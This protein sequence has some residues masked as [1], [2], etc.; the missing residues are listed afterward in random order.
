MRNSTETKVVFRVKSPE[1]AQ[2]L[3]Y[4]VLPLNLE[5]PV[6]ASI[7][8]TQ[9]GYA[10]GKLQNET[11]AVHEGDGESEAVHAAEGTSRG[12]TELETWASALSR[13]TGTSTASGSASSFG[14][15]FSEGAANTLASMESMT[16]S[17][18]PNTQTFLAVNL[19]LGMNIGSADSSS[20]SLISSKTFQSAESLSR[21]RGAFGN[22]RAHQLRRRRTCYNRCYHRFARQIARQEQDPRQH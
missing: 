13:A 19:P 20:Q 17:Y 9:I 22:P 18:D 10:I 1:E 6:Q 11:Y 12:R 3:A 7:R 8:P 21:F 14:R 5:V 2:A 4:D 15:G 16:F